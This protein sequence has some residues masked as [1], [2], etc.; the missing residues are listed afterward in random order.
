MA[1]QRQLEFFLLRYV[2]DAV[3]DEFVNLGVVLIEPGKNGWG[4]VDARFIRDWR[5][6][7]S[8]DPEVDIEML[9]ALE[10]DIQAQLRDTPSREAL[11]KRLTD[12]FS[13]LI[14][15]SPMKACLALEPA[16]EL[17]TLAS[18]Y[19][20]ASVHRGTRIV[21]G[22]QQILAL[23]RDAFE[24]AG[25]WK[26]LMQSVSAALYTRPGD[27]LKFDFAYRIGESIKIFH[28]VSLK[29]SLD[30][31]VILASRYPSIAEGIQQKERASSILTAIV[32]DAFDGNDQ[33]VQ[34]ALTMMKEATIRIEAAARMPVIAEV[35][36]QELMA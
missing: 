1:E 12:S 3:K 21:S 30:Q 20:D 10:R 28:A 25:V 2:P 6:V 16:K 18:L 22:R 4:F 29:A 32:D 26:L 24:Q 7:R 8:L 14:Q 34:F 5:R 35:A 15:V 31:A 13:N 36:R 9:E 23:M 33:Q 27:P 11:L 17:E 19:V